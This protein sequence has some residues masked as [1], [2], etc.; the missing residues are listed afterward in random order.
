MGI[1]KRT[2]TIGE[3]KYT[4]ETFGAKQGMQVL[5]ALLRF[6]GPSF[7]EAISVGDVEVNLRR[8]LEA[9]ATSAKDED[10]TFLTDAFAGRCTVEV[11]AT[12]A[13]GQVSTQV[14]LAKIFD[15]HFAGGSGLRNLVQWLGWCAKENFA[16]F[17]AGLPADLPGRK[18]N[19]EDPSQSLKG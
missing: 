11:V 18:S 5:M 4:L 7:A 3:H 15:S 14:P 19:Q 17:L 2:T 13:K 16:D 1:E 9:F 10:L 6:V 12:T 8:A